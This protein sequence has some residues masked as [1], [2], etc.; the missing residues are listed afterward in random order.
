MISLGVD[1]GG[2]S[3]KVAAWGDNRQLWIGR[4]DMY[5]RPDRPQL[6]TALQQAATQ[7]NGQRF[8]AVGIC[9]PGLM[10]QERRAVSLSVNIPGLVDWPLDDLLREGIGPLLPAAAILPD[11]GAAAYDIYTSRQLTGRLLVL[12][13]G[14]GVGAAVMDPDGLLRVDGDSPGHLGQVDVSIEGQ[15]IIGP[16][17]GAGSLEGYIGAAALRNRYGEN[18]AAALPTLDKSAPPLR[19][20]ARIIRI[21][22][23]LYRPHDICL[24]GGIGNALRPLLPPLRELIDT[25]LTRIARQGWTL[26]CGDHDHHAALGI[27]KFAASRTTIN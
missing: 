4:S 25:N 14:T 9:V 13:L 8:D 3:V 22:H 5:V 26:T 15:P 19:A 10:D 1:I 20:L 12:V 16:D 23:A 24:A 21:A 2:T 6:L 7:A 18:F 17:G 27:A 11:S